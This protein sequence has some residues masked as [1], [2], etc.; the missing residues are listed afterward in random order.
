MFQ[1]VPKNLTDRKDGFDS[2]WIPGFHC[3]QV[4][5]RLISPIKD[6]L[7]WCSG[8]RLKSNAESFNTKAYL[9][10]RYIS[11]SARLKET[12]LTGSPKIDVF[13]YQS[14]D[15]KLKS[16]QPQSRHS[17]NHKM[18]VENSSQAVE[19][20]W[21]HCLEIQTFNLFWQ[22]HGPLQVHWPTLRC[23]GSSLTSSLP[24]IIWDQRLH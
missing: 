2:Q 19:S 13:F 14:L 9:S 3:T 10:N 12:A 7:M 6:R 15:G 17:P 18:L 21:A 24:C 5:P 16:S 8:W 11:M 20:F 1:L 23:I 4:P 22:N